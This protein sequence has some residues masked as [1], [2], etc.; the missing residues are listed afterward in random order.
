M[1]LLK[2]LNYSDTI[3]DELTDEMIEA[4]TTPMSINQS[5]QIWSQLNDDEKNIEY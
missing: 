2:R 3:S 1:N 4:Q 5:N